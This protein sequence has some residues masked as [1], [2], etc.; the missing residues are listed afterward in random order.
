M[1]GVSLHC[2]EVDVRTK[3]PT[4]VWGWNVDLGPGTYWFH[5]KRGRIQVWSWSLIYDG[6]YRRRHW[7][8]RQ[9]IATSHR[10][11]VITVLSCP[12]SKRRR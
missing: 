7:F 8:V 11:D 5:R 3:G 9:E 10:S 6:S 4:R 2:K 1:S 12:R